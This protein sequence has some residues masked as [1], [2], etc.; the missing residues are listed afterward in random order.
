MGLLHS[1]ES[2][3][4]MSSA[5]YQNP[6]ESTLEVTGWLYDLRAGDDVA[7]ARLWKYLQPR[8]TEL[9]RRS[10]QTMKSACYDEDDVAQSAFHALCAAVQNGQYN[11]LADRSSI[12]N[13]AAAIALNKV[14]TRANYNAALRRGGGMTRMQLNAGPDMPSTDLSSEEQVM[15]QEECERLISLL[16]RDE[17]KAVAMLKIE[18]YTN[19]EIATL[20]GCTRRSVQRRLDIIRSIWSQ[21]L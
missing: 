6:A 17:V 9:G 12:W 20:Q 5:Y 2:K 3:R 14:R 15:M 11:D 16:H 10:L 19:E 21:Q 4:D 13:L 8:L 7:A 18:G 1:D